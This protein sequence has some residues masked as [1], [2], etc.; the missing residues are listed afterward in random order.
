MSKSHSFI[1]C[2]SFQNRFLQNPVV[3]PNVN[4]R[5]SS[6][7]GNRI[8]SS[9]DTL[10]SSFKNKIDGKQLSVFLPLPAHPP[11]SQIEELSGDII[12]RVRLW[13]KVPKNTGASRETERERWNIPSEINGASSWWR[14]EKKGLGLSRLLFRKHLPRRP[15]T[16]GGH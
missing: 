14:V 15:T 3:F 12:V 8:S 2:M 11:V 13:R 1:T 5:H 7:A 9:R 10:S 4:F 16:M 6:P